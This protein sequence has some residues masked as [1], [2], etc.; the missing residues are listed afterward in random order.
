MLRPLLMIAWREARGLQG[1]LLGAASLVLGIL[2]V[3]L[4]AAIREQD[5]V[6]YFAT[7]G[8]LIFASPYMVPFLPESPADKKLSL[9]FPQGYARLPLGTFP[10]VAAVFVTRTALYLA[11]AL[12]SLALGRLCLFLAVSSG[13]EAQQFAALRDTL[14]I[15][16]WM[17]PAIFTLALGVSWLPRWM[18]PAGVLA[19]AG[20]IIAMARYDAYVHFYP[21][22]GVVGLAL[23]YWGA[24]RA[25]SNAG[26]R[27]T[28]TFEWN[29]GK[30]RVTP[31]ASAMAAQRWFE[32]Q[33]M[34]RPR[35]AILAYGCSIAFGLIF[36]VGGVRV[37]GQSLDV[38]LLLRLGLFFPL[39]SFV[40]VTGFSCAIATVRTP[41]SRVFDALRPMTNWGLQCARFQGVALYVLGWTLVMAIPLCCLP[42]VRT[43]AASFVPEIHV[44]FDS[45]YATTCALWLA[46]VFAV[47]WGACFFS[48][49]VLLYGGI[50]AVILANLCRLPLESVLFALF[51]LAFFGTAFV[52]YRRGAMNRAATMLIIASGLTGALFFEALYSVIATALHAEKLAVPFQAAWGTATAALYLAFPVVATALNINLRRHR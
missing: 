47:L 44:L 20:L 15:F 1:A 22:L 6:L 9:R 2:P 31:F 8:T 42:F 7:I 14:G 51:F 16:S 39:A 25:R 13:G 17:L 24:S 10:A 28:R 26:A 48:I 18:L 36:A 35:G 43:E 29:L 21:A 23:G 50:A 46:L 34:L 41:E 30:G 19:I 40:A 12:P 11:L 37:E 45:S 32:I 4:Y 52:A 49:Y 3:V 38:S 33:S 27:S 5:S